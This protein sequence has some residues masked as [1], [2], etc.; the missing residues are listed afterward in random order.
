[1][2]L[3]AK[4]KKH[5]GWL[6]TSFSAEGVCAAVVKRRADDKPL[7]QAAVMY[8]GRKPLPSA[9]LEKLN[10]DVQAQSYRNTTLLGAGEYQLLT[11]DAPNVPPEELRTAVRWRLKDMLDFP[12]ADATVDVVDIPGDKNGPGRA[13]SLFAV[14]ARNGAVAQRQA[15]YGAC[16]IALSVIDIPEM[17][18]RN[19]AGLMETQGRGL[20]MLSFD[21][22]GGLLTVT[23]DGELYLARRIDVTVAQ[24]ADAGDAQRQQYYDKI[25]LELQRSFDH[26]DRQFHFITVAR[27][28]LAPTGSDGLHAYLADN[29]YMPVEA[30]DLAALFDFSRV[31]E[32]LPPAGQARFFLALGAALRQE[33]M[34]A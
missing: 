10:R 26:F 1:M 19:I 18:Q 7:V 20:A 32:L 29:L 15:L 11:V 31:P 33:E 12:A 28:V 9:T 4:A 5:E 2:G 6:A 14:A 23:F 17:A 24:L 25:T 3:F 34:P 27:L 30:L 16:K 13:Q 22:E 21:G 8:A